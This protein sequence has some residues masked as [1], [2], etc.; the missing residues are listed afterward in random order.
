[1]SN[2]ATVRPYADTTQ[3]AV[4]S[5]MLVHLVGACMEMSRQLQA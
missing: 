3:Q 2:V 4:S 5:T 1:M